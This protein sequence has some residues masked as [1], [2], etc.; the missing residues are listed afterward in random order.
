MKGLL[1]GVNWMT[2]ARGAGIDPQ[3]RQA[4]GTMALPSWAS[5]RWQNEPEHAGPDCEIRLVNDDRDIHQYEGRI[6]L[7]DG[8]E[9]TRVEDLPEETQPT[10]IRKI[11]GALPLP[12]FEIIMQAATMCIGSHAVTYDNEDELQDMLTV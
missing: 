10:D 11:Y 6:A 12:T 7:H 3:T 9:Y 1:I 8:Q 4:D 2:G 5:L